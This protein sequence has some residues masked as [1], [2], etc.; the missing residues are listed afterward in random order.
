MNKVAPAISRTVFGKIA[1]IPV[2]LFSI[3]FENG[4]SA[5]FT[6]YGCILQSL[7]IPNRLG[8]LEEVVMGF[9]HLHEYESDPYYHG[10]IVGR[11]ANRIKNGTF[12]LNG[13]AYQLSVNQ[14]PHHLHGGYNG[15]NKA[16][17]EVQD[18]VV[19][20]HEV[21]IGLFHL[22]KQGIDG[23][24][25]NVS[26][27][28]NFIFNP[29]ELK[30]NIEAHTDQDTPLNITYH[31][32]FNL[33]GWRKASI[34]DHFLKLNAHAF[35][36][37]DVDLIPLHG[38]TFVQDSAFDFRKSTNILEAIRSKEQDNGPMQGFDHCFVLHSGEPAA[39]LYSSTSGIGLDI[40]T[41]QKGMQVYTPHYQVAGKD[42]FYAICLEPQYFPDGPNR[43]PSEDAILRK[44]QSYA[45]W[46]VYQFHL[47]STV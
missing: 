20:D 1:G 12:Q 41:N 6:N 28:A 8:E 29:M 47:I 43:N 24:P 21:R 46:S 36:Q 13:N 45:F 33:N 22:S 30:I 44:G 16:I 11:Y 39:S 26:M 18:I 2:D 40:F 17:W 7:K 27:K 19:N 32:Y 35:L 25:G 23:Y 9:E 4:L 38:S 15:F 34:N 42:D 5:S 31:P 3:D 10:A 37:V 14:P